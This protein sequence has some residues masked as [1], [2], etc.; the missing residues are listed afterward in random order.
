LRREPLGR[1]LESTPA[2]WPGRYRYPE[3]AAKKELSPTQ[4]GG[5]KQLVSSYQTLGD[6]LVRPADLDL[7][8]KAASARSASSSWR[9]RDEGW[10][11]FVHPQ[12][13]ALDDI[14]R[15]AVKIVTTPK[16]T[17]TAHSV[18]FPVTVRNTLPATKD[19][20][21]RNAIKVRLEFISANGQR[22]TVTPSQDMANMQIPAQAGVTS[23]AQVDAKANGTVRV[24]LRAYTLDGQHPV[25]A[26]FPIDVQAT[27]AGT[28]GWLIAIAA[29]IVLVGGSALRIRQVTR[30]RAAAPDAAGTP[31]GDATPEGPSTGHGPADA[32]PD[33][34]EPHPAQVV[35]PPSETDRGASPRN[36]ESLDV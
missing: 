15:N 35:P 14:R 9:D 11:A 34:V 16:V 25:G 36:P 30:E 24:T 13:D 21:Q 10:M 8:A 4:I 28:I 5:V 31:A 2:K 3:S 27:Q 19:D 33:V 18:Q 32:E 6:L 26:P 29:G 22:L 12:Q 20:P 7:E 23:N 1:L 17:T